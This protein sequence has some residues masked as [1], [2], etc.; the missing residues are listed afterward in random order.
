MNCKPTEISSNEIMGKAVFSIPS[1]PF[2]KPSS[3]KAI[4]NPFSFASDK[5]FGYRPFSAAQEKTTSGSFS[6]K[7]HKEMMRKI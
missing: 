2:T 5:N 3:K 7:A 1:N 6:S 4:L